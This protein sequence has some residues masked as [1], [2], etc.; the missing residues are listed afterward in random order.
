MQAMTHNKSFALTFTLHGERSYTKIH[1]DDDLT[2]LNYF[3]FFFP[4]AVLIDIE[5]SIVQIVIEEINEN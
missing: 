5:E 2:A 4:E 3:N 1:C